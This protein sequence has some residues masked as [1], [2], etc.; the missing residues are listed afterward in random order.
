MTVGNTLFFCSV[1]ELIVTVPNLKKSLKKKRQIHE[2]FICST[3]FQSVR[4]SKNKNDFPFC[5]NPPASSSQD[6]VLDL[7]RSKKTIEL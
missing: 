1:T 7:A 3:N 6:L 2:Y 4:Y 5:R